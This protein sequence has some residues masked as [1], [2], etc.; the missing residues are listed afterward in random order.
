MKTPKSEYSIRTF[1]GLELNY[2]ICN[3]TQIKMFISFS[4]QDLHST[5]EAEFYLIEPR[6]GRNSVE[7]CSEYFI[8]PICGVSYFFVDIVILEYD[9]QF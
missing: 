1:L 9:L 3:N 7:S 8:C 6:L 2:E 4:I 5:F